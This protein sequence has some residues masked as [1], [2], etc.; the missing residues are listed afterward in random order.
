MNALAVRGPALIDPSVMA[1]SLET[2]AA[3]AF[4]THAQILD[5]SVRWKT[6]KAPTRVLWRLA[7]DRAARSAWASQFSP[8]AGER[9]IGAPDPMTI[10]AAE[11]AQVVTPRARGSLTVHYN[12]L[13]RLARDRDLVWR[14]CVMAG[15]Q[16]VAA[17]RTA[18]V[19]EPA[20]KR[21]SPPSSFE[22]AAA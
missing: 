5:K 7:A 16:A 15:L 20:G 12:R 11:F 13:A 19:A 2:F 22:G 14:A 17:E 6:A 3:A 10:F 18:A 4:D 21:L 1:G 8:L 9:L